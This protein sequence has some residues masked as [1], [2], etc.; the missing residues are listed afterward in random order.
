MYLIQYM[1]GCF[2]IMNDLSELHHINKQENNVERHRVKR[3]I[4]IVFEHKWITYLAMG[5]FCSL[6]LLDNNI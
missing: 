1:V 6:T 3:K 5:K 2:K 4:Y